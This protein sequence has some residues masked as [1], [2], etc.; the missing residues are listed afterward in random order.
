MAIQTLP[1]TNGDSSDPEDLWKA[2]Q[3]YEDKTGGDV[4][5]IPHNGN[6]SNAMMFQTK[7][8]DDIAR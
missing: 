1:Y 3:A 2:L 4:L 7:R 5:A 6:L 8:V